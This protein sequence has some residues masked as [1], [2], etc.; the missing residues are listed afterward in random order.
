MAVRKVGF[1]GVRTRVLADMV[2]LSRD[3]LALLVDLSL[4]AEPHLAT[5]DRGDALLALDLPKLTPSER[6]VVS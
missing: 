3:G 5:S 6:S 1:V 4:V 2:R